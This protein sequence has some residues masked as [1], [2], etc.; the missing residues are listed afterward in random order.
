[1]AYNFLISGQTLISGRMKALLRTCLAHKVPQYLAVIIALRKLV[2][3]GDSF[4][5]FKAIRGRM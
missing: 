5:F 1:M 4:L 3:N 2:D